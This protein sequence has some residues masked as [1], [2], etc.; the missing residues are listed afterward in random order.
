M[1]TTALTT[2]Q[3]LLA[4]AF[5]L[6]GSFKAFRYELARERMS[7]V[8]SV[9]RPLVTFI[10]VA[11][12]LG[13]LGLLLPWL[14]GIATFLTPLAAAGLVLTMLLAAGFHLRRG[15]LQAVPVNLI[16]LCMAAFV[17]YGRW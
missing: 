5:A 7:W 11:E 12:L 8:A 3:I 10:G 14:T 1:T 2:T 17:S 15:E 16:F 9:P 6:A 4:L 13:G